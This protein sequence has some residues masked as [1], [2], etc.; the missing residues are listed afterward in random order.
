MQ[1]IAAILKTVTTH[2]IFNNHTLGYQSVS[3]DSVLA[4]SRSEVI[5]FAYLSDS[6]SEI[7]GNS[8]SILDTIVLS[9]LISGIINLILN[10]S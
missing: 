10:I 2:K 3:D 9:I 1:H 7:D 6:I 4:I 5:P 8:I